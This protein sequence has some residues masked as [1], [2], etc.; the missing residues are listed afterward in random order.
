MNLY[1]YGLSFLAFLLVACSSSND[2]DL[3]TPDL[4]TVMSQEESVQDDFDSDI[5][6]SNFERYWNS[7][8]KEDNP[9][10]NEELI[11]TYNLKQIMDEDFNWDEGKGGYFYL[12][13]F[14]CYEK[15][16]GTVPAGYID[17]NHPVGL[18]DPDAY[19]PAVFWGFCINEASGEEIYS[20]GTPFFQNGEWWTFASTDIYSNALEECRKIYDTCKIFVAPFAT[21]T[22]IVIPDDYIVTTDGPFNEY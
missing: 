8:L 11:L 20:Y 1:K 9:L 14:T 5:A 15:V 22:K 17:E 13:E 2:I 16:R 12:D 4:T 21:R 18:A 6:F 10:T 3:S 19:L 7:I